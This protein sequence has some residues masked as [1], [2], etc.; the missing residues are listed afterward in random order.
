MECEVPACSAGFCYICGEPNDHNSGHW[1]TGNACPRYNHPEDANAL[2]DHGGPHAEDDLDGPQ[3]RYHPAWNP[4]GDPEVPDLF[5]HVVRDEMDALAAAL[6]PPPNEETLEELFDDAFDVAFFSR[7]MT[8]VLQDFRETDRLIWE[9]EVHARDNRGIAERPPPE[10]RN[11]HHLLHL[12]QA[13][14]SV[15]AAHLFHA[16]ERPL[17][18]EWK[19]MF[20]RSYDEQIDAFY[21]DSEQERALWPS[22]D[23]I[24]DRYKLAVAGRMEELMAQAP[25][26]DE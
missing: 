15:Y 7:E 26:E 9:I 12:L 23:A 24:Y 20:I 3:P 13:G 10:L 2:Y 14:V 5:Q 18:V 8:L 25:P 22:I 4:D 1:E 17:G 11:F 16:M 19:E 6:D 21:R